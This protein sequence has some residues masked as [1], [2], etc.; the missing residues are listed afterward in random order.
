MD[1]EIMARVDMFLTDDWKLFINELNTLPWFTS[2]S[3]YPKLFSITWIKY[4]KLIDKLI[5]L[6]ID[7]KNRDSRLKLL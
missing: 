7:R 5:N 3:M 1:C 6:A 4:P 2:I